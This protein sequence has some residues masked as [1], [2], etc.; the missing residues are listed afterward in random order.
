MTGPFIFGT[1]TFSLLFLSVD[2]LLRAA[3]M[4]VE[5]GNSFGTAVHFVMSNIPAVLAYAFPMAALL[6]CLMAFGR[7]SSDS[8]VIAMKAGGIS[9][10]RLAIP[11]LVMTLLLALVALYLTDRVVPQA[12]YEARTLL[13][14]QMVNDPDNN[15]W[16]QNLQVKDIASDGTDRVVLVRIFKPKEGFMQTVTV[17]FYKGDGIT[18]TKCVRRM[19]ADYAQ[20]QPGDGWMMH[21]VHTEDL[22]DQQNVKTSSYSEQMVLPL[23][24]TPQE[25][26][27]RPRGRDEM[28]RSQLLVKAALEQQYH[29]G[30]PDKKVY[31][32]LVEYHSR[33]ALPFSCFVFGLFGIPLGLQPHRTSKSIGLGLSIVF[34]FIYYLLM[35]ISRS[36]GEGGILSPFI[37]SWLPNTVF[38]GVGLALLVKA[39]E[40]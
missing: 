26:A 22:D 10:Y 31:S 6:A 13:L 3:R 19:Y 28:T 38:G 27:T 36:L 12:N 29:Q 16:M 34:I 35:T 24:Q 40:I 11:G 21:K 17:L 25:L 30:K 4:V 2:T 7:L 20:W 39:G 15:K 5:D 14:N 23:S 32:Y 37:A 1:S 9:F 18:T 8:E 33:V